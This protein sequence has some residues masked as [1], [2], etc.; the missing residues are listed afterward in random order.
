M[1]RFGVL[2]PLTVERESV[3]LALPS[4]R[5]R[6]LLGALIVDPGAAVSMDD[7][8]DRLWGEAPPRT[9]VTALHG[10][11]SRLRKMLGDDALLTIPNGYRLTVDADQVDSGRF[12]HLVAQAQQERVASTRSSL[13]REALGL[14]RGPALADFC[15]EVSAFVGCGL[16]RR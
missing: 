2:G 4:G 6:M 7:L 13:L 10:H 8:I 15:Y 11:V 1:L 5:A 3:S 16:G 14:W 9:A 12:R